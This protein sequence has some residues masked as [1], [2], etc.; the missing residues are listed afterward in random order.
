MK[1]ITALLIAA[2]MIMTAAF[3]LSACGSKDEEEEEATEE[4]TEAQ[5][6][7]TAEDEAETEANGDVVTTLVPDGEDLG[8]D[9]PLQMESVVLYKDGTVKIVPTDELKKNELGEN[10]E[11]T[12]I[13]P[14]AD[15]GKVKKIYLMRLGNGGFRTIVALIDDGTMSAI[16]PQALIQDHIA[17]VMDNLGGRDNFIGAEQRTEE[18]GFGIAGITEDDNEVMIDPVLLSDE[19]RQTADDEDE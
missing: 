3:A 4:T 9:I 16:N 15:S 11:E 10:S 13:T 1:R 8:D 6:E 19:A 14:F 7:G 12:F 5:D 18:D 2:L 17:V